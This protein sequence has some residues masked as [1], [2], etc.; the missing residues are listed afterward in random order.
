M[1]S[2]KSTPVLF[3]FL[4]PLRKKAKKKLFAIRFLWALS[5]QSFSAFLRKQLLSTGVFQLLFKLGGRFVNKFTSRLLNLS[6]K[7]NKFGSSFL[8]LREKFA[9]AYRKILRKFY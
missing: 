1:Q 4:F 8:I 7:T 9:L 5:S 6:L 3:L 2:A